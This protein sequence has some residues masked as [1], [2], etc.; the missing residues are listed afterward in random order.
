MIALFAVLFFIV[1]VG[2]H[3]EYDWRRRNRK[4]K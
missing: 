4:G 1:A 2:A 3:A